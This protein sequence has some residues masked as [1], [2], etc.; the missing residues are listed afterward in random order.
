MPIASIGWK[1]FS[2][3]LLLCAL[4]LI[5]GW[6]T[7]GIAVL[8][9]GLYI[10]YFFRDPRR[11]PPEGEG[12]IVSPADG[13]VDTIEV[14][15]HSVFPG[16]RALKVGIFLSVFDVHINRA[17]LKGQVVE[18]KHQSGRFLN[19]MNKNSSL[20]NES[21]LIVFE[22][23]NGPVL[24]KQIAG[25]I[26]RRILCSLKKGDAV[27]RGDRIGLICFGSRTEAYLP[28]NTRIEVTCGMKVKGG[29]SILG[30][31]LPE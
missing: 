27:E 29:S 16:G 13:K 11:I 30:V 23:E 14:V 10:L 9:V 12:N 20:V 4:L 17:P 24:V 18:T 8:L 5:L 19:A 15:E 25:L 26:A 31:L 21:N 28:V 22:T 3:F 1:F 6:T 2:P 7:A